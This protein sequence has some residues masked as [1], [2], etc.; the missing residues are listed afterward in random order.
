[1]EV[2]GHAESSG[3]RC[4][5][6]KRFTVL[7]RCKDVKQEVFQPGTTMAIGNCGIGS[8][9]VHTIKDGTSAMSKPEFSLGDARR[10]GENRGNGCGGGL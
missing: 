2:F 8:G 6:D 9:T 10:E 7:S 3:S 5:N 4:T 1:V